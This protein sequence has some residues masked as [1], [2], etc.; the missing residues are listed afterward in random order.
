MTLTAAA[1]SQQSFESWQC[2]R[3]GMWNLTSSTFRETGST[4]ITHE[5]EELT[6]TVDL[7]Y[8][9]FSTERLDCNLAIVRFLPCSH[10]AP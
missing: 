6:P 5:G 9:P 4:C 2:C 10:S 7:D 8:L 1:E 3:S